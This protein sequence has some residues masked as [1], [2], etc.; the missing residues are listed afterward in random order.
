M[1]TVGLP[2]DPDG[3][4]KDSNRLYECSHKFCKKHYLTQQGIT[5]HIRTEHGGK[6]TYS[7]VPLSAGEFD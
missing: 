6:G 5:D 7:R 4:S 2:P 1:A 3:D